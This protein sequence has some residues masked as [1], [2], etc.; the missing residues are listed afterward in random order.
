MF[1]TWPAKDAQQWELVMVGTDLMTSINTTATYINYGIGWIQP[2]AFFSYRAYSKSVVYYVKATQLQV[3]VHE[4]QLLMGR[5]IEVDFRPRKIEHKADG[6]YLALNGKLGVYVKSNQKV[7]MM[8]VKGYVKKEGHLII[9]SESN[10]NK[11]KKNG[12]VTRT[13]GSRKRFG[14]NLPRDFERN[15]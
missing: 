9:I 7:D 2:L 4:P 14:G 3:F 6:R 11:E 5:Y 1:G 8:H 12:K 15:P 13:T 10:L